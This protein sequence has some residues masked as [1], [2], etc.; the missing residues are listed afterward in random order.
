MK[1][2]LK[3]AV[4]VRQQAVVGAAGVAAEPSGCAL[5]LVVYEALSY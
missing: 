4:R 5:K 3:E 2:T 1:H